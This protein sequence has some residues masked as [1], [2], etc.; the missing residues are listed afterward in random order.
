MIRRLPSFVLALLIVALFLA[1]L[2]AA[3]AL[4]QRHRCEWLATHKTTSPA[5]WTYYCGSSS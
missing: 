5:A 2:V 1:F 3:A 4:G